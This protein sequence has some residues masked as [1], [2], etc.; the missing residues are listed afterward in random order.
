MTIVSRGKM[1]KEGK[2]RKGKG[3]KEKERKGRKAV[4]R[5]IS[6]GNVSSFLGKGG[7]G[8]LSVE[9]IPYGTQRKRNESRVKGGKEKQACNQREGEREDARDRERIREKED[10]GEILR[11]RDRERGERRPLGIQSYSF[12][13]KRP[14]NSNFIHRHSLSSTPTSS[15]S[16][17]LPPSNVLD[18]IIIRTIKKNN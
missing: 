16:S 14:F 1:A 15:S 18:S 4:I 17:S 7:A 13:S 10:A 6:C 11:R 12:I 3:R 9:E 5:R 8:I 2:E